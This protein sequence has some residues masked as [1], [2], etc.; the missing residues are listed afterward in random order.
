MSETNHN[1]PPKLCSEMVK[2]AAV[3]M[4]QAVVCACG[5]VEYEPSKA[6]PSIIEGGFTIRPGKIKRCPDNALN[7][8]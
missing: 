4:G 6:G 2:A 8:I 7:N 5:R 3:A 1:A